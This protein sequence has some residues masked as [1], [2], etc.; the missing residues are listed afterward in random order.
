MEAERRVDGTTGVEYTKMEFMCL[1]GGTS[2]WDRAKPRPESLRSSVHP[3]YTERWDDEQEHGAV[4]HDNGS[5]MVKAGFSGEDTPR[6]IFA[7]VVGQQDGKEA[8]RP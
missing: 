1:Y 6:A 8:A 2:E 3:V 4:V 7:A 5:G